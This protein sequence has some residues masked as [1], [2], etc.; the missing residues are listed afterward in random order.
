VLADLVIAIVGSLVIELT[1]SPESVS[2]DLEVIA[3]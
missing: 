1:P 2:G 3:H